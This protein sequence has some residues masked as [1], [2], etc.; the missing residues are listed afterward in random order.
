MAKKVISVETKSVSF[1]FDE[2]GI[3]TFDLSKVSD[4]MLIQLALHGASQKIGDN[5][6]GAKAATDGTEIDPNVWSFGQAESARDQIY[7]GDWNV[8]RAGGGAGAVSDLARAVAEAFPDYSL[9]EAVAKIADCSKEEK[10]ALRKFPAIAVV[11]ER[12]KAERA[13]AK[14]ERLEAEAADADSTTVMDILG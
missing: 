11:L 14:L 12:L 8:R 4:E 13:A 3:V 5:Y 10:A 1:D 6:A 2:A 7:S 9:E